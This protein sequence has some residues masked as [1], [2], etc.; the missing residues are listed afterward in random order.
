MCFLNVVEGARLVG[1]ADAD[2][3]HLAARLVH[4]QVA[5]SV[6]L[7]GPR[8]HLEQPRRGVVATWGLDATE[9]HPRCA[10]RLAAHV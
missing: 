5:L 2:T 9:M 4:H 6:V 8:R 10:I 3:L 1:V 7:E